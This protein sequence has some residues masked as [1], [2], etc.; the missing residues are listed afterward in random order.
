MLLKVH[1]SD[2]HLEVF[3]EKRREVSDENGGLFH[4]DISNME[5]RYQ[6]KLNSDMM[7]DYC[8]AL[9]IDVPRAKCSRTASTVTF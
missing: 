1:F 2:S 4:H 6:G 8:W 5:K 7:A 9:K 3:L